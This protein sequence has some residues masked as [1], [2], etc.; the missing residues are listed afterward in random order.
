[1][2]LIGARSK[3]LRLPLLREV[4]RLRQKSFFPRPPL[5]TTNT[6]CTISGAVAVRKRRRKTMRGAKRFVFDQLVLAG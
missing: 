6:Y 5:L 4:G 3:G 1:V 2:I